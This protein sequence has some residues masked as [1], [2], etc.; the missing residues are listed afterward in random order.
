M[1]E[2]SLLAKL[3]EIIEK[4]SP[5]EF[6]LSLKEYFDII[7]S[8]RKFKIFLRHLNIKK[9]EDMLELNRINVEID[10]LAKQIHEIFKKKETLDE[11]TSLI[12]DKINNYFLGKLRISPNPHSVV[13]EW[14]SECL[15]KSEKNELNEEKKLYLNFHKN[16]FESLDKLNK[17]KATWRYYKE[18]K[19]YLATQKFR[20]DGVKNQKDEFLPYFKKFHNKYISLNPDWR[21][22]S[23]EKFQELRIL[24]QEKGWLKAILRIPSIFKLEYDLILAMGYLLIV[25]LGALFLFFIIKSDFTHSL[26][27]LGLPKLNW[28]FYWTFLILY[29]FIIIAFYF[30]R[31][32]LK[33]NNLYFKKIDRIFNLYTFLAGILI[34]LFVSVGFN[35]LTFQYGSSLSKSFI[36][37]NYLSYRGEEFISKNIQEISNII[38][39]GKDNERFFVV[40]KGANCHFNLTIKQNNKANLY[41][42]QICQ[43]SI[44]ESVCNPPIKDFYYGNNLYGFD[45]DTYNKGEF[46]FEIHFEFKDENN[47]HS[48][49]IVINFKDIVK[50]PEEIQDL[51]NKKNSF[52]LTIVSLGIFSIL[53]GVVNIKKLTEPLK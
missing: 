36:P 33:R 48:S 52:L 41:A 10:K 24:K 50:T 5:E 19:I 11:N 27:I 35:L 22:I 9:K 28:F 34:F 29:I 43:N 40:K 6:L 15:E 12:L 17:K 23:A 49:P 8:E 18:I 42:L 47:V 4:G 44:N 21:E 13:L 3:A 37:N 25:I 31:F 38:C 20:P 14:I 30:F 32:L 39:T 51:E 45:I 26:Q 2:N 7:S 1:E 46:E 16:Y 53:A